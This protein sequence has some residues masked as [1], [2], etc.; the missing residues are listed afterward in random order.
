MTTHINVLFCHISKRFIYLK[1]VNAQQFLDIIPTTNVA[2]TLA[3]LMLTIY[4]RKFNTLWHFINLKL[5]PAVLSAEL[6]VY[7]AKFLGK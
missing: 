7:V 5:K 4:C 3:S 1:H 2:A 6:Y